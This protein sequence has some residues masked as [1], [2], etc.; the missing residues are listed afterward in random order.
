[1]SPLIARRRP[2]DVLTVDVALALAGEA[3]A[4]TRRP[5]VFAAHDLAVATGGLWMA[6][7][8]GVEWLPPD[9]V[10]VTRVFGAADGVVALPD[11]M[12]GEAAFAAGLGNRVEVF[13]ADGR[14]L[15][16]GRNGG[17]VRLGFVILP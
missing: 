7:G 2:A 15:D 4:I 17:G 11:Q 6:T 9:G 3:D 10:P 8:R 12:Y 5:L 13:G 1:M 14:V 16:A